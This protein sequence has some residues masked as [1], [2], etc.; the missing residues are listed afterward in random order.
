METW[1][2][3]PRL[4]KAKTGVGC[5]G[6][7]PKVPMDLDKRNKTRIRRVLGEGGTEWQNG[8]NKPAR[9]C[10]DGNGEI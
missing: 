7:H 1:E 3:Y 2:R 4:Y 6:F 5:D 10:I 9:R 8:R